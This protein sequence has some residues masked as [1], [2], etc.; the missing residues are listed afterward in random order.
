[1]FRADSG[2]HDQDLFAGTLDTGALVLLLCNKPGP[3]TPSPNCMR[4]TAFG[5]GL[6]LSYRFKRTQLAQWREIDA[7]VRALLAKF[8]DKK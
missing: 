3:D 7:G 8:R 2:Y 4:D 1:V 5:D 6:A